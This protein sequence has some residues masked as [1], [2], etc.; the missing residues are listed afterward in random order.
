MDYGLRIPTRTRIKR[1]TDCDSA[2][3]IL[4]R[5]EGSDMGLKGRSQQ[6]HMVNGGTGTLP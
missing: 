5:L 1:I 2:P 4:D 6:D 3:R